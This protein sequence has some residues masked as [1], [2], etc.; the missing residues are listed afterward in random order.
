ML[1][2]DSPQPYGRDI[3]KILAPCSVE[4]DWW[5]T[6]IDLSEQMNSQLN[7]DAF[8]AYWTALS[9]HIQGLQGMVLQQLDKA[10][11]DCE[12]KIKTLNIE[13]FHHAAQTVDSLPSA[14][15][16]QWVSVTTKKKKHPLLSKWFGRVGWFQ[17]ESEVI[18][19]KLDRKEAQQDLIV[20]SRDLCERLDEHVDW[21]RTQQCFHRYRAPVMEELTSAE[22][23]G[24][25]SN[26]CSAEQ[27]E[28][29]KQ[30]KE[31]LASLRDQLDSNTKRSKEIPPSI[32]RPEV[33]ARPIRAARSDASLLRKLFHSYRELGFHRQLLAS[34]NAVSSSNSPKTLLCLGG[35]RRDHQELIALLTHR[36]KD[37][38]TVPLVSGLN[39]WC[40]PD[41]EAPRFF[42][43][44]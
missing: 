9:E 3:P 33:T 11:T 10:E 35:N 26:T 8:L 20:Y 14:P 24:K 4:K 23:M 22:K 27:L 42:F 37:I 13:P 15:K 6:L 34:V 38:D 28:G 39:V 2:S 25:A 17:K 32:S 5:N 16:P 1:L 29:L 21:W 12:A 7:D 30:A 31:E 36:L 41:A 44:V 18:E 43:H 40:D 19:Y